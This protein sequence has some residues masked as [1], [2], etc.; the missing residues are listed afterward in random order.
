QYVFITTIHGRKVKLV[1]KFKLPVLVTPDSFIK[2]KE[3]KN[4]FVLFL[5]N[6]MRLKSWLPPRLSI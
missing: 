1:K 4:S 6:I 2:S 3:N 5:L